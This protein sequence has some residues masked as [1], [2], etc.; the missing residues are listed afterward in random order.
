MKTTK[1]DKTVP[2]RRCQSLLKVGFPC[3]Q[4]AGPKVSTC[5]PSPTPNEGPPR[6][7]SAVQ[8][9]E[10]E[11]LS[12]ARGAPG[13]E[14]APDAAGSSDRHSGARP[15]PCGGRGPRGSRPQQGAHLRG[16]LPASHARPLTAPRRLKSGLRKVP[17][18]PPRRPGN[19]FALSGRWATSASNP[20]AV[21]R[22][23]KG[24]P[25]GWGEGSWVHGK[26]RIR[27]EATGRGVQSRS[28]RGTPNVV[29][30]ARPAP[31]L[32]FLSPRA[33]AKPPEDLEPCYG[34][35][36]PSPG[37]APGFGYQFQSLGSRESCQARKDPQVLPTWPCLWTDEVTG[38]VA[39][40]T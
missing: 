12:T 29:E 39:T 38:E 4:P 2:R 26:P 36:Q 25:W 9:E 11:E 40:S 27:G 3:V 33:G 17:Q 31:P 13:G 8:G 14:D 7:E 28:L 30:L 16:G 5:S 1:S 19:V 20:A 22:K 37:V 6:A 34:R 23:N 32:P 10:L 18:A 24:V 21:P 15:V 35:P